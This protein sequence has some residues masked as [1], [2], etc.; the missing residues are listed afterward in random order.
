MSSPEEPTNED[1]QL[2]MKPLQSPEN[3]ETSMGL[4]QS[5]LS[6]YEEHMIDEGH[7]AAEEEFDSFER[8]KEIQRL[9]KDGHD[10]MRVPHNTKVISKRVCK[11][12][13]ELGY[14]DVHAARPQRAMSRFKD[15]DDVM[16]PQDE[17]TADA[18]LLR[19]LKYANRERG[20]QG[21]TIHLL[22]L[23]VEH[24]RTVMEAQN[25]VLRQMQEK[26][27]ASADR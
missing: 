26:D 8:E 19:R 24:L 21:G 9:M 20:K 10:I 12:C 11:K 27:E 14:P 3:T 15:G 13:D 25:I 7:K 22:R 1:M 23:E 16:G 4:G 17:S 18:D 2:G 6:D 5:H